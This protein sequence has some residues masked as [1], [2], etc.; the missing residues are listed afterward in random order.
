MSGS[1][2]LMANLIYQTITAISI[3]PHI[4]HDFFKLT[5]SGIYKASHE[6]DEK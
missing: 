4:A 2:V 1:T 6:Q 3:Y 5:M